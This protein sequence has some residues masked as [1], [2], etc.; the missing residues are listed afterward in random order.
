[1]EWQLVNFCFVSYIF[2]IHKHQTPGNPLPWHHSSPVLL[3]NCNILL[4]SKFW[5]KATH[6]TAFLYTYF[7]SSQTKT[8]P[9]STAESC[10]FLRCVSSQHHWKSRGALQA[11]QV[12]INVLAKKKPTKKRVCKWICCS[13]Q[14]EEVF[15]CVCFFGAAIWKNPNETRESRTSCRS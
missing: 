6:V 11:A 4:H 13:Y 3:K 2:I 9:P 5:L 1:M 14:L 10:C 15:E 7:S 8:I 12:L